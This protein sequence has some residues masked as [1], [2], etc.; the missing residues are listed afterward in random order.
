MDLITNLPPSEGYDG[1]VYDC[2]L[3]IVDHGLSK[4]AIFIPLTKTATAKDIANV[5]IDQFYR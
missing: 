4:G 1:K 2:I 3:S 5:F